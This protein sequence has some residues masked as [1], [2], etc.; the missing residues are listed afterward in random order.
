LLFV[1]P[2]PIADAESKKDSSEAVTAKVSHASAG[3][4]RKLPQRQSGQRKNELA[5]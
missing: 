5:R 4:H 1:N 3:M 2:L